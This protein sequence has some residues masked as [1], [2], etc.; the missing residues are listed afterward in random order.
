MRNWECGMAK[1]EC[2]RWNA[3]GGMR[4]AECQKSMRNAEYQNGMGNWGG[5]LRA[6]AGYKVQGVCS[7]NGLIRVNP[8]P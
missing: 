3:E 2:G 1:K 5:K 6:G 8:E 7:D 4:N